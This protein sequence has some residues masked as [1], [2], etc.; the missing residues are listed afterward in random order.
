MLCQIAT[1]LRERSSKATPLFAFATQSRFAAF[2]FDGTADTAG[3]TGAIGAGA[4][5]AG[6]LGAG[7]GVVACAAGAGV[8]AA[9]GA[10]VGVAVAAEPVDLAA[11]A[12]LGAAG[13][14]AAGFFVATGA[15]TGTA[16]VED[17][18][19]AN[20]SE[21]PATTSRA[22]RSIRRFVAR[23][24]AGAAATAAGTGAAGVGDTAASGA[25]AVVEV[26]GAGAGTGAATGA[27]AGG[28]TT[29]A[30]ATAGR[31]D[32]TT[33]LDGGVT[34]PAGTTGATEAA[35]GAL[36]TIGGAGSCLTVGTSPH[37]PHVVAGSRIS[38][39][40]FVHRVIHTFPENTGCVPGRQGAYRELSRRSPLP[41][42]LCVTSRLQLWRRTDR[43]R[44]VPPKGGW[45][46]SREGASHLFS[47]LEPIGWTKSPG[48]SRLGVPVAGPRRGS[49]RRSGRC[50][51]GGARR[52]DCRPPRPR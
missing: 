37:T 31:A 14:G 42:T 6:A 23:G 25:G 36:T 22:A 18:S 20:V 7:A 45:H 17:L 35:S 1:L 10:G 19:M 13:F 33:G 38:R 26:A 4:G 52:P 49:R 47:R 11:G 9:A 8:G 28:A 39:S 32:A 5:V 40:H 50:S 46:L 15:V 27:G 43:F 34:G 21:P 12:G 41:P 16:G 44:A 3:A 2:H 51:P 30:V 29:G 48:I 24:A